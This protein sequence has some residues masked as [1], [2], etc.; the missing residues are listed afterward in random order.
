MKLSPRRAALRLRA[1]CGGDGHRD[2]FG[3]PR[4]RDAPRPRPRAERRGDSGARAER[5]DSPSARARTRAIGRGRE[6]SALGIEAREPEARGSS[7]ASALRD[8]VGPARRRWPRA[9]LHPRIPNDASNDWALTRVF[10]RA[11]QGVRCGLRHDCVYAPGIPTCSL[12]ARPRVSVAGARARRLAAVFAKHATL[13]LQKRRSNVERGAARLAAELIK[14]QSF[15]AAVAGGGGGAAA[16]APSAVLAPALAQRVLLE[17]DPK[18]YVGRHLAMRLPMAAAAASTGL[19]L[20][21]FAAALAPGYRAARHV[22]FTRLGFSEFALGLLMLSQL[23][24]IDVEQ[25]LGNVAAIKLLH[26]LTLVRRCPA[27]LAKADTSDLS[28][29]SAGPRGRPSAHFLGQRARAC[30]GGGGRR[31]WTPARVPRRWATP[32]LH[33]RGLESVRKALHDQLYPIFRH[34]CSLGTVAQQ[35][36]KKLCLE[37][38]LLFVNDISL[39]ASGAAACHAGSG[40]APTAD[41]EPRRYAALGYAD[42]R[43]IM[44]AKMRKEVG[45]SRADGLARA[46]LDGRRPL[47]SSRCS[48][49]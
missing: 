34:Y 15:A 35:S 4:N 10:L 43:W 47:T 38:F 25:G 8:P 3:F 9:G 14:R 32:T 11:R 42:F 20:A 21:E 7:L 24:T 37:T 1:L 48:S 41:G 23:Q 31:R 36:S 17:W 12:C 2:I 40:P 33:Q 39:S 6:P 16:A 22:E 26:A 27:V 18:A 30:G 44:G 45:P 29:A 13:P 49:S 46:T 5:R 19:T 28:S